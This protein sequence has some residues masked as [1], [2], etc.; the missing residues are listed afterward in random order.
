MLLRRFCLTKR[1]APVSLIIL[2]LL[3]IIYSSSYV[4]TSLDWETLHTR[5]RLH[6]RRSVRFVEIFRLYNYYPRAAQVTYGNDSLARNRLLCWVLTNP[7]NVKS[8]LPL[9]RSTWSPRC[10]KTLF[11]SSRH[12][13]LRRSWPLIGLNISGVESKRNNAIKAKRAWEYVYDHYR[14]NYDWFMKTG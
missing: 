7:L 8:R 11:F 6:L 9:V 5:L 4:L 2:S 14:A 3:S 1:T 12:D 10:D 13:P